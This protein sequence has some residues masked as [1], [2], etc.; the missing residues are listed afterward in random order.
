[1]ALAPGAD[2]GAVEVFEPRGVDAPVAPVA[3]LPLRQSEPL[4]HV[5]LAKRP[6][7]AAVAVHD[8]AVSVR[9][10]PHGERAVARAMSRSRTQQLSAADLAAERAQQAPQVDHGDASSTSARK[11]PMLP[12]AKAVTA[13]VQLWVRARRISPS[14]T[15]A[16]SAASTPL[17]ISSRVK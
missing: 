12:S 6:V 2:G 5:V 11:T 7:V 9:G 14:E 15:P 16:R 1:M 13:A 17:Q 4:A 8:E 3:G 10:R